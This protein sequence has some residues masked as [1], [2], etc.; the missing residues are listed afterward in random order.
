MEIN[1]L[2]NEDCLVGMDKI[3]D[4][5][6]DLILCDLP[7]GATSM[8]WDS[9]IPI[10]KLWEQY[11]RII[12]DNGVI[13]LFGNEPFSSLL[14]CSN[15]KLYR[16]DWYWLKNRPNGMGYAK[17]QPMRYIENV[18]VFYKNPSTF[19]KQMIEREGAKKDCYKNEHYC[20]DSNHVKM[21][22]VKK[23]YDPKMV[24]PSNLLLFNVIPNKDGGRLHPTEKPI[25]LLEYF[26]NTYTNEGDLVLDNCMG[27]GSTIE[28]CINTNRNYIGFEIDTS[29]FIT[30]CNRINQ[31]F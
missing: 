25:N 24:N 22:K 26:I 11:E 1:K 4:A 9:I 30:A 29:Y 10:D 13:C 19:N 2:Y 18:C 3:D 7:Y 20:G 6:V 27:S 23:F 8:K 31:E 14:R 5:S 21:E 28:A 16:Y 17:F 12:K 15:I